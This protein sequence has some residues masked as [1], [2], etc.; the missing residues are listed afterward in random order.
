M[1]DTQETYHA[2]LHGDPWHFYNQF[3]ARHPPLPLDRPHRLGGPKN[4]DEVTTFWVA[5][6]DGASIWPEVNQLCVFN[7]SG[8]EKAPDLFLMF[9]FGSMVGWLYLHFAFGQG[10]N[11]LVRIQ[12][13]A[14]DL[15]PK[16]FIASLCVVRC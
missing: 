14:K 16:R 7:R 6:A 9:F 15:N 12:Q 10:P 4:A 11:C 13:S 5:G 1:V 3:S 2:R 8:F